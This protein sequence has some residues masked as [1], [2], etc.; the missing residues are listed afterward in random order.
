T[1]ARAREPHLKAHR[2]H[3]THGRRGGC[4]RWPWPC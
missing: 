4:I 2:P 1:H 3:P